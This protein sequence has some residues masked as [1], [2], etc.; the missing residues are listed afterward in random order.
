MF[1]SIF[2]DIFFPYLNNSEAEQMQP[3]SYSSFKTQLDSQFSLCF[4]QPRHSV[5]TFNITSKVWLASFLGLDS[6]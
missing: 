4:F 5:A 1:P 6:V 3:K 2:K